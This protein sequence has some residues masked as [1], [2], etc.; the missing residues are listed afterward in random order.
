[1]HGGHYQAISQ[2]LLGVRAPG[3]IQDGDKGG[4]NNKDLGLKL[5][6]NGDLRLSNNNLMEKSGSRGGLQP[7]QP[8]RGSAPRAP[9]RLGVHMLP[10][11]G[12]KGVRARPAAGGTASAADRVVDEAAIAAAISVSLLRP[13]M[14]GGLKRRGPRAA[15]DPAVVTG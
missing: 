9:I 10:I 13:S 6:I 7:T 15:F 5:E 14:A 8:P 11:V 3:R 1:M 12:K 2:I 4:L